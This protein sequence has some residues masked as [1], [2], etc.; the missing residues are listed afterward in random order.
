MKFIVFSDLHVH[1]YK[2]F[3]AD[4]RRLENLLDVIAE[5]YDA[6]ARLRANILFCGDLFNNMQILQTEVAARVTKLFWEKSNYYRMEPCVN[7]ILISGNHDYATRNSLDRAAISGNAVL[8]GVGDNVSIIDN[9]SWNMFGSDVYVYGIPYFDDKNDF[10]VALEKASK[11]AEDK[12]NTILLMHQTVG[13]GLDM[14]EED[15]DPLDPL[16]N[17]FDVVF[18]GHI[19][20]YSQVADDWYN[21]GSPIHR[22]ASDVGQDKGYLIYDTETKIVERVILDKYPKFRQLP[23]DQDLPEE[24]EGD[25]IVQVPPVQE[26]TMDEEEVMEKFDQ[27]GIARETLLN[28]YLELQLADASDKFKKQVHSYGK[29]MLRYVS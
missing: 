11:E 23:A 25:Y 19:H 17:A 2:R 7:F 27:E 26:L 14:V 10:R 21:V 15:I 4:N 8:D 20:Q 3:N 24:W 29:S 9:R 22:D 18:N 6:A 13:L 28:N 16:F 5:M 1:K 12:P